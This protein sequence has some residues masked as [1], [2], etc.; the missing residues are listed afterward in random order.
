MQR[1]F[2][3]ACDS[4]FSKSLFHR[5]SVLLV[6]WWCAQNRMSLPGYSAKT[7]LPFDER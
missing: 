2:Q 4:R 7:D 3:E 1:R 6:E 5:Q